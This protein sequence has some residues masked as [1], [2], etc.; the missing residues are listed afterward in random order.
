MAL[1]KLSLLKNKLQDVI[2]PK[3]EDIIESDNIFEDH[4]PSSPTNKKKTEKPQK[5]QL[6]ESQGM[7]PQQQIKKTIQNSGGR[8]SSH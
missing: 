4:T 6:K 8:P 1:I 7:M 5:S 3:D 2:E